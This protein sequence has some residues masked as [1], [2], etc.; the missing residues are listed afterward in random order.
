VVG[1]AAGGLIIVLV[2]GLSGYSH[3]LLYLLFWV[4]WRM[5][6]DYVLSPYLM[7]KGVQLNPMLV[8]FGVLAGDQIAGVLGMFLSVPLLAILRV[9]FV[10]LRRVRSLDLVAPRREL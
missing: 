9:L 7:S 1:P 6:Q 4:V 8:L 2:T 3:V 5:V 10:R